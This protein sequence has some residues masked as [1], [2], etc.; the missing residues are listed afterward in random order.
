MEEK[1]FNEQTSENEITNLQAEAAANEDLKF[2]EPA[3]SDADSK[4]ELYE[5][6]DYA[7]LAKEDLAALKA[8]FPELAAISDITE[9]ENPLRY[10][11]LRDLGLSAEEAY[12]ATSKRRTRSDN[13]S[14]LYGGIPKTAKSPLGTMSEKELIGAREIFSDLS[15][16]EIRNLYKKVTQ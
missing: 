3:A 5:G 16:S 15:D 7:L 4:P 2:A 12:L 10:A 1:D 8:E 13:R 11:A 6:T 14:H 9:L